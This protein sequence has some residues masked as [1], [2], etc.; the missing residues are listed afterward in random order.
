MRFADL[1]ETGKYGTL[2]RQEKYGSKRYTASHLGMIGWLGNS[3]MVH[4]SRK[5]DVRRLQELL[6]EGTTER[7]PSV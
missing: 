6:V 1:P 7:S 2:N 4:M 3:W 5:L